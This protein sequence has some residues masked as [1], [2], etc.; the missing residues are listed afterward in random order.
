MSA[1]KPTWPTNITAPMASFVIIISLA[2]AYSTTGRFPM[3]CGDPSLLLDPPFVHLCGDGAPVVGRRQGVSRGEQ[4]N[5]EYRTAESRRTD[6]GGG[7]GSH[8]R[9][10][11]QSREGEEG[12]GSQD[13]RDGE[14]MKDEG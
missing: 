13:L 12:T 14:G 11:A 10:G 1:N 8:G 9:I 6:S 2:N 4:Q 3:G 5:I 7:G